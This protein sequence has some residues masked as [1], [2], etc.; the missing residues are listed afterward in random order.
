ML[1]LKY[2]YDQ[3]SAHDQHLDEN[4]KYKE[5]M[6]SLYLLFNALQLHHVKGYH[7]FT[8]CKECG[9][10][11]LWASKE[12][13]TG[14]SKVPLV[15]EELKQDPKLFGYCFY[16]RKEHNRFVENFDSNESSLKIHLGTIND[17]LD[18]KE[19]QKLF[20]KIIRDNKLA[21][22]VGNESSES[23]LLKPL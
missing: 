3:F 16:D 14:V 8:C 18:V 11:Y 21:I 4:S 17:D 15:I 10:N 2:D 23:I 7:R 1:T 20:M 9:H 5:F 19:L 6:S 22:S 13:K 12:K